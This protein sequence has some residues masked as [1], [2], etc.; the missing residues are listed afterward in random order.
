MSFPSVRQ[1]G[2]ST[3]ASSLSAGDR[4][5]ACGAPALARARNAEGSVLLFCRHHGQSFVAA[6]QEQGFQVETFYETLNPDA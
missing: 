2:V 5:D 4:C 3:P 6:L 1:Q